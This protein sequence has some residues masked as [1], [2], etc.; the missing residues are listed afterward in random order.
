MEVTPFFAAAALLRIH[1][2]SASFPQ[3]KWEFLLVE[4]LANN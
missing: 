1:K 2:A 4:G 3:Q